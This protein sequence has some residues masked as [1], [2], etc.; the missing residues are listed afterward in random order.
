MSKC[1]R[2]RDILE[3]RLVSDLGQHSDREKSCPGE[4]DFPRK[5][6]SPMPSLGSLKFRITALTAPLDYIL[7]HS[8]HYGSIGEPT[9]SQVPFPGGL[10]TKRGKERRTW[11][12]H[13]SVPRRRCDY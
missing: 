13:W 5:R 12:T 9:S 3:L 11:L 6:T 2:N 1:N 4:R 8:L 10:T 7:A